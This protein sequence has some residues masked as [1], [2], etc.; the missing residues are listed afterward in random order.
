MALALPLTSSLAYQYGVA[1]AREGSYQRK[2]SVANPRF[3]DM[4]KFYKKYVNLYCMDFKSFVR[5]VRA[6]GKG[7]VGR[8][9]GGLESL[10][11]LEKLGEQELLLLLESLEQEEGDGAGSG[12]TPPLVEKEEPEGG[13]LGGGSA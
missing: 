10:D 11:D 4:I 1:L 13:E 7:R 2:V 8:L 9:L 12:D 3:T 5:Y 6:G